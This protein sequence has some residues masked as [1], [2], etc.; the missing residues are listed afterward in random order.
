MADCA[1]PVKALL[2]IPLLLCGGCAIER[3]NP[4]PYGS[5]VMSHTRFFGL[6]ANVPVGGGE[7]MGVTLGWGS[8]TWTVIPVSTNKVYAAQI[9]DTFRLG[10]GINPFETT[11]TEDINAGWEGQ[12]PPARHNQLFVP[13]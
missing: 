2:L 12:P 6:K 8:G 13:P 7:V 5:A 3:F 9:S 11:I 10:Q 1:L 4:P